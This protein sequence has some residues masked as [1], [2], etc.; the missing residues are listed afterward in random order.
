MV[1][2][3][4]DGAETTTTSDYQDYPAERAEF[5]LRGESDPKG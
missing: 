5:D 4:P 3:Q 1:A 2:A